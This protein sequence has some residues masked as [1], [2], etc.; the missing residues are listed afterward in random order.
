MRAESLADQQ[1]ELTLQAWL[2]PERVAQE[3]LS[4]ALPPVLVARAALQ[5]PEC[6]AGHS[7]AFWLEG[8]PATGE[9]GLLGSIAE[10][11]LLLEMAAQL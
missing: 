4:Q 11:E 2:R 5:P 9:S 8:Q 7:A 1:A 3:A 6:R 10:L